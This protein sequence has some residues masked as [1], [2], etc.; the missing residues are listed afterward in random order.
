VTQEKAD[1]RNLKRVLLAVLTANTI[2]Q[3]YRP[4]IH[5]VKKKEKMSLF[6]IM[7]IEQFLTKVLST[8]K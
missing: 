2:K 5:I 6:S 8:L 3:Y 1:A 4:K 7:N